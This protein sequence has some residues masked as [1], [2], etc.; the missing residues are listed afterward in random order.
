MS[1]MI[2]QDQTTV[3]KHAPESGESTLLA[4]IDRA[5]KDLNCD[6][7]KMQ[8][9]LDM[10]YQILDRHDTAEF[11]Q[12]MSAA[13]GEIP[14]IGKNGHVSLGGKG[15]YKFTRWEDM[16]SRVR[17]ILSKHGL[18]LSFTTRSAENGM[19]TVI[20]T[21]TH[22]NGKSQSAE[23]DLPLDTGQGRNALQ[24]FG[25]SISYGKRYC[26]EM[27]LNI[28][29]T[30]EDTDGVALPSQKEALISSQQKEQITTLLERLQ[31]GPNHLLSFFGINAVDDL[32]ARKFN[33]ALKGLQSKIQQREAHN[34]Q[35]QR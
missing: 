9:L 22:T 11:S 21:V 16:D 18:R 2:T 12:A 33:Q 19:K 14:Q 30:N 34:A 10:H 8:S 35:S 31:I 4:I 13:S 27:L 6:I 29:R 7:N 25:S 17:P 32:P 3:E 26:T 1:A 5:S 23:I 20:G 28:V 24:A 15:G